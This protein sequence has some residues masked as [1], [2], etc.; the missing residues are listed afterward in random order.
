MLLVRAPIR[1]CQGRTC[2]L[3][4][5]AL[6]SAGPDVHGQSGPAPIDLRDCGLSR[7]SHR[8]D[9]VPV[10]SAFRAEAAC[11]CPWLRG[12]PL[13]RRRC[14]RRRRHR[15]YV[16]VFM[17]RPMRA[18][19]RISPAPGL[20]I[21][22]SAQEDE[23]ELACSEVPNSPETPP[24]DST[25]RRGASSRVGTSLL[26]VAK[27]ASVKYEKQLRQ[28]R[29]LSK[30]IDLAWATLHTVLTIH[31]I[32]SSLAV[33]MSRRGFLCCRPFSSAF[34]SIGPL[35]AHRSNATSHDTL[36][37]N[38]GYDDTQHPCLWRRFS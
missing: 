37:E 24:G 9:S 2:T 16:G 23:G 31:E 35:R 13:P 17:L 1:K 20:P 4:R 25:R 21:P 26:L 12:L 7:V 27:G 18:V 6:D 34:V 15:R 14:H 32:Q 22:F 30:K 38:H 33:A 3:S 11:A 5:N 36:R 19:S 28:T 8:E 10:I 29:V